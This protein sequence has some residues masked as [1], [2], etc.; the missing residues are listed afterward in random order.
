M[1]NPLLRPI[2]GAGSPPASKKNLGF[3]FSPRKCLWSLY[4]Y[5]VAFF[6]SPSGNIILNTKKNITMDTPPVIKVT[7]FHGSSDSSETAI[8]KKLRI[9]P[10]KT[11]LRSNRPGWPRSPGSIPPGTKT[12]DPRPPP[13][14]EAKTWLEGRRSQSKTES[15]PTKIQALWES[16]FLCSISGLRRW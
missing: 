5:T 7:S 9:Q 2:A 4:S 11:R 13:C 12:W 3:V 15:A 14:M 10:A 1:V 8:L 6:A 16:N